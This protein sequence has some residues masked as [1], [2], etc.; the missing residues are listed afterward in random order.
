M[1]ELR[2][3][4][5]ACDTDLAADS[6]DVWIC[7]FECT[8]CTDCAAT[9]A[10]NACPNDKGNLVSRPIRTPEMLEKFPASTERKHNPELVPA[11]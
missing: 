7:S 2:P 4:C 10:D 11:G 6:P 3:N 5:E 9:F 8:W 1:L